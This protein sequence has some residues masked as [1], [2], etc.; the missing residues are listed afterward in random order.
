MSKGQV[1]ALAVLT[2]MLGGAVCE[3][4]AVDGRPDSGVWLAGAT[5][6]YGSS[7]VLLLLAVVAGAQ[8][9]SARR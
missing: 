7:A 2:W 6:W 9:L 4:T 1:A 8:W 5:L 3:I